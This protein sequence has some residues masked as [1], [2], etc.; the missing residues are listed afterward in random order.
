MLNLAYPFITPLVVAFHRQMTP[1]IEGLFIY[2]I[3]Y[4]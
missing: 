2:R 4:N 1:T 3:K